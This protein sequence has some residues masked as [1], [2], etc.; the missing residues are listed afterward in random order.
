MQCQELRESLF[1][2]NHALIN[3]S[4]PQNQTC[5]AANRRVS[6]CSNNLYFMQIKKCASYCSQNFFTHA[7]NHTRFFLI[8]LNFPPNS[9]EFIKVIDRKKKKKKADD[10]S[11]E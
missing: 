7:P 8:S 1:Q 9:Y 11:V 5:L 4:E 6:R 2:G 3:A 10:T